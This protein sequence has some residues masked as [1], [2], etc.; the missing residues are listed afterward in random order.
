MAIPVPHELDTNTVF[1][2]LQN[3]RA[4]RMAMQQQMLQQQAQER[5][6]LQQQIDQAAQRTED[7][8]D[9]DFD[10]RMRMAEMMGKLGMAPDVGGGIRP[11]TARGQDIQR[12]HQIGQGTTEMARQ[13]TAQK[14]KMEQAR[15]RREFLQAR[16]AER[17]RQ[18]IKESD[19]MYQAKLGQVGAPKPINAGDVGQARGLVREGMFPDTPEGFQAAYE[20]VLAQKRKTGTEIARAGIPPTG[21]AQTAMQKEWLQILDEEQLVKNI[22]RLLDPRGT[23][24]PDYDKFLGWG[25]R[26][27]SLVDVTRENVA[28]LP[29]GPIASKLGL[30]PTEQME[31]QEYQEF[32]ATVQKYKSEKFHDLIGGAQ[33]PSEVKNLV[34]A[35]LNPAMSPTQ[36]KAALE[37]LKVTLATKKQILAETLLKGFQLT[38]RQ[39]DPYNNPGDAKLVQN[40]SARIAQQPKYAKI[41]G[42]AAGQRM[43]E[44]LAAGESPQD[45]VANLIMWG[46][47]DRDEGMQ[48][49]ESMGY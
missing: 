42:A 33:T 18:G 21:A 49:L 30:S 45:A 26:L 15:D 32:Y 20:H 13:Q 29:L 37:T 25:A 23:G 22:D 28:T 24:E 11:G 39:L 10:K 48:I 4:R 31:L 35:I 16:A 41:R 34:G 36:F 17:H 38:N 46:Q 9:K 6:M 43:R 12:A 44:M 19:P 1:H 40:I 2:A 3:V 47:I 14:A 7:R 8:R 27:S 5:A